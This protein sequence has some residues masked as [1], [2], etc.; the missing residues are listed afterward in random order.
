MAN[1]DWAFGLA[2]QYAIGGGSPRTER[3]PLKAAYTTKIYKGAPVLW[4]NT[5]AHLKACAVTNPATVIGVAA[6]FYA[7]SATTKT[8][9]AVWPASE[10]IFLVQSDGTTTTSALTSVQQKNFSF[11]NQTAGSTTTGISG[12]ELDFSSGSTTVD[13]PFRV[14][15]LGGEIGESAGANMKLLGRF[16]AGIPYEQASTVP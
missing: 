11:V 3:Y 6:E 5:S 13:K 15:G 7:G 1:K 9:L 10:H 12:M 2:P 4:N 14:I 8:T 16:N